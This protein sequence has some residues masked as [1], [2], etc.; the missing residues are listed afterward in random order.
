MTIGLKYAPIKLPSFWLAISTGV[1]L[2]AALPVYLELST[3][4]LS[5]FNSKNFPSTNLFA[6]LWG[7]KIALIP[8]VILYALADM[9][10]RWYIPLWPAT[11]IVL[12][13]IWIGIL[14]WTWMKVGYLALSAQW[15][16][17]TPDINIALIIVGVILCTSAILRTP[18]K[19]GF[20]VAVTPS[21]LL[22]IVGL[23]F[24]KHLQ[25]LETYN[26]YAGTVYMLLPALAVLGAIPT[27]S[28]AHQPDRISILDMALA[29]IGSLIMII[30]IFSLSSL[31][32]QGL[33]LG[34][35]D[36]PL[37]FAENAQIAFPALLVGMVIITTITMRVLSTDLQGD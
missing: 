12:S 8:L 25:S 18:R 22:L 32:R 17:L 26:A 9:A 10:K 36:Y 31:G 14:I 2:L 24:M 6:I 27:L 3:P 37:T 20:F 23:L 33:P 34:Y 30:A 19:F 15:L 7:L 4:G 35:P 13:L 28:R 5:I 16:V 11:T 29:W 1:I 21:I